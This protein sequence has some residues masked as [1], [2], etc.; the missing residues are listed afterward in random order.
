MRSP[1]LVVCSIAFIVVACSSNDGGGTTDGGQGSGT[2]AET[3]GGT[4]S[5][6]TTCLGAFLGTCFDPSG[7]CTAGATGETYSNG[8]KLLKSGT[9]WTATSSKG[10]TCYTVDD[11]GS[12]TLVFHVGANTLTVT[13]GGNQVRWTCP[14]GSPANFTA[15]AFDNSECA[16]YVPNAGKCK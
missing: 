5:L 2:D 6:S 7:T 8:A 3:G 14:D 15:S 1:L 11:D 9:T 12:G 13:T 16:L 4:C 10:D